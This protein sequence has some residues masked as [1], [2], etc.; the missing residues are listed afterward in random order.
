MAYTQLLY[1][2]VFSTKY[3]E[4]V[5]TKPE[6][7]K[8]YAYMH[9]ILKNKKC[10][11]YIIN[12]VE[13]HVHIITHIHQTVA[14]ADLVRTIKANSSK[15][16]KDNDYFPDFIGWQTKYAAFSYSIE[17]KKNLINYVARQ[18]EHHEKQSF[19]EETIKLLKKHKVEYNEKFLFPKKEKETPKE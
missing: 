13:N 15:W 17:A 3:R 5:L 18:E 16:I 10:H 1:Q 11:V 12:G 8:L 7:D 4:N 19:E 9:G 6:R 14:I 2:I